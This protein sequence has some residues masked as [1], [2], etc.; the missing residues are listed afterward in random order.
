M[1][2]AKRAGL[3]AF[4]APFLAFA[5]PVCGHA[6]DLPETMPPPAEKPQAR[7]LPETMATPAPKP[8]ERPADAPAPAPP[9]SAMPDEETRC[10]ERLK[11]LGAVFEEAAPISEPEGCA[12]AH[13]LIVSKLSATV[14]L[15][16]QAVLT[17]AMAEASAR[18]VRDHAAPLAK[19]EFGTPLVT[20]EQASSYVCR[21]RR[22][23][24]KLSEHAFANA[25]DWSALT[26]ADGTRIEVRAHDATKEPRA[27]KL[28]STLHKRACGPFAT[29]LGPGSDA[30]HA[31]HFHFDLAKRRDP[32][33]Q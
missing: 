24:A 23:G 13:P 22:S 17:C 12:A 18:F 14:A 9:A 19:E 2:T 15:E 11:A 21:P 26:L 31:D 7:E 25:L 27:F 33:C 5:P 16:P 20:V 4:L 28:I 30:D 32:F 1:S 6:Q 3:A 29:V 8:R 10:R